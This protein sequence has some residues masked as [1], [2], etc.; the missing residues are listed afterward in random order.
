MA[1][2]P[3][4]TLALALPAASV[5]GC[6]CGAAKCPARQIEFTV[7]SGVAAVEVCGEADDCVLADVGEQSFTMKPPPTE[8]WTTSSRSHRPQ[9]PI[10]WWTI[11]SLDAEGTVLTR[12]VL[13]PE[14][15]RPT[16]CHCSYS[17]EVEVLATGVRQVGVEPAPTLTFPPSGQR[18]GMSA[19]VTQN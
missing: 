16:R 12:E 9:P 18:V 7:G 5:A 2:L 10:E 13:V 4:A 17:I 3:L 11:S 1:F 8:T 15:A 14:F 6:G 19:A